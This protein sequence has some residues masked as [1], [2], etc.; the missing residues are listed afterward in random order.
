MRTLR[1]CS[2]AGD[3]DRPPSCQYRWMANTV[4]DLVHRF[5]EQAWNR[6]DDAVVDTLLAEEFVFRGSL[7]QE[8]RGRD[9]WRAYRDEVRRAVPD[10]HNEIIEL[11][12]EGD[13]AAARLR[14]TG[15][16]H[17]LLLGRQGRG[18]A[19]AYGGAAFFHS[20]GG[21]LSAAWVLGDLDTLR[22][23][24]EPTTPGPGIGD[25]A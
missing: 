14:W 12:T 19:I 20:A 4:K 17:G 16:H 11:V 5:Y 2:R 6:W 23:Q 13:R 24:V 8:T 1:A 21:Q 18:Q 7:G 22:Q 9:Q 15:H 10:F 25:E 3:R